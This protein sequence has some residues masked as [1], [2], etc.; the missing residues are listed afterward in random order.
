MMN[1]GRGEMMKNAQLNDRGQVTIPK[2]IREKAHLKPKDL[3]KIDLNKQGQIVITKRDYFDD[4]DDLIRRDLVCEDYAPFELEIKVAE[5]KK[6]LASAL[7]EM[8][9]K[10]EMEIVSGEYVTLDELKEELNSE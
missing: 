6:E 1:M 10:V 4:I 2:N 9:K 3:V 5:K 8:V 7:L